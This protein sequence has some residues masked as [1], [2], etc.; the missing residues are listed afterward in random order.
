[1][2]AKLFDKAVDETQYEVGDEAFVFHP[3]GVLEVGKKLRAS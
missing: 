1:V 2:V 3:P